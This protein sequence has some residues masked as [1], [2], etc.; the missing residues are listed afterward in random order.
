MIHVIA[1]LVY[2]ALAVAAL[3]W[4]YRVMR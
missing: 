2:W 4:G 3:V 1:Y